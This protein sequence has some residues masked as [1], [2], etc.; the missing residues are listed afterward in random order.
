[1]Y[2]QLYARILSVV[3]TIVFIVNHGSCQNTTT[4]TSTVSTTT[5]GISSTS[6]IQTTT[7]AA[8]RCR[9]CTHCM[10]LLICRCIERRRGRRRHLVGLVDREQQRLLSGRHEWYERHE[11]H[12]AVVALLFGP[13][14]DRH[15]M[16]DGQR[17]ARRPRSRECHVP[18]YVCTRASAHIRRAH[19]QAHR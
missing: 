12:S 1:M 3:Y 5:T 4:S 13:Y 14:S 18:M 8:S 7:A 17:I 9:M 2:T 19:M 10:R 16:S 6:N 11:W 15:E